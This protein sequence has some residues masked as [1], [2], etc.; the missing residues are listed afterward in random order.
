MAVQDDLRRLSKWTAFTLV[1]PF[2]LWARLL[3]VGSRADF[4]KPMMAL[5]FYVPLARTAQ[6]PDSNSVR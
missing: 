2:K 6:F 1:T 5:G 3:P 4:N